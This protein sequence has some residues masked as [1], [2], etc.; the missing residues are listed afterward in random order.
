MS[1][2]FLTGR[3]GIGK[4]TI[5]RKV[6]N[7]MDL[8]IGGYMTERIYEGYYRRYI[9]KSLKNPSEQFTIVRS[10]SRDNSKIWFPQA[11]EKGLT[12]L[13]DKSLKNDDMIVLDELGSSEKDIVVF[14]SKVFEVLD[15]DKI[16]F[17]VLKDEDCEFL[18]AIK[19]RADVRVIRITE[20]NRDYIWEEII[21]LLKALCK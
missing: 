13:L 16:V 8:S 18:N 20:E 1:N 5:L 4:S 17:G 14:T 21:D 10:D 7:N 15:S 2:L 12:P 19:N 6:L 3:I 11:F 9:A